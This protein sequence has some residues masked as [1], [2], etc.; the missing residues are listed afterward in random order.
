[1]NNKNK[2]FHKENEQTY[3][4]LVQGIQSKLKIGS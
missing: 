3:E 2:E 4:V 1:M